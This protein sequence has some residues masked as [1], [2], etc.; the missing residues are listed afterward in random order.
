MSFLFCSQV[1]TTLTSS[2][3]SLIHN[4]EWW[5]YVFLIRSFSE[6]QKKEHFLSLPVSLQALVRTTWLYWAWGDTMCSDL[7]TWYLKPEGGASFWA[8]CSNLLIL[9]TV[10][11]EKVLNKLADL[12]KNSDNYTLNLFL[13]NDIQPKS[14]WAWLLKYSTFLYLLKCVFLNVPADI[15]Y[16]SFPDRF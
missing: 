2:L 15:S 3:I 16:F 1:F 8:L 7:F 4:D 10:F 11:E 5:D 13:Q 6:Q 14:K 12:H 9:V